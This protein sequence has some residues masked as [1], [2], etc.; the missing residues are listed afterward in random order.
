MGVRIE[1]CAFNRRRDGSA[2]AEMRQYHLWHQGDTQWNDF[3]V[4]PPVKH[5]VAIR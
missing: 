1:F 3:G 5:V 4:E 2:G